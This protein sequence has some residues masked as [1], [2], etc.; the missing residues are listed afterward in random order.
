MSKDIKKLYLICSTI[1]AVLLAAI[2]LDKFGG[3]IAVA[4]AFAGLSALTLLGIRKRAS[5][6]IQKREALLIVVLIGIIF[7][8]AIQASGFFFSFYENPYFV[9]KNGRLWLTRIIPSII[10]IISGEIIRNI[11]LAQKGRVA[12]VTAYF[13]GVMSEVLLFYQIT[14]LNSLYRVMDLVALTIFPAITANIY[15]HYASRR[16]GVVPNVVFRLI[17]TLY[18]YFFAT[19][20]A[21]SDALL[22]CVKLI[23]PL[24]MLAIVSSLFEKRKRNAVKKNKR[25]TVISVLLT[26]VIVIPIAMLISCQFR[27][28]ALVIATES[29]TGE[30][31]K[32]DMIVYERYDKQTIGV[33]Q[34]IV[35]LK[36]NSKIVH[37]VVEIKNIGGE[38]RYYTKGDAN[39]DLDEG[40]RVQGDI[41]GLTDIKVAYVG[42]PTLWLR[43]TI[44]NLGKEGT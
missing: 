15:F 33:G 36:D 3:K 20:S 37:R 35:F 4:L 40:Y 44:K 22:A 1:F 12:G 34:V 29:M 21:M 14:Q 7:V 28:G 31:N 25:L 26:L 43:D 41:V 13:A 30:I 23:F 8:I 17:T 9:K 38:I 24:I 19:L 27:F 32:G 2:A 5:H 16:F 6:S 10:I 18:I 42:Y 11:L 39:D